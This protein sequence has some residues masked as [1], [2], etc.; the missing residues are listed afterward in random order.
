V[1]LSGASF[2]SVAEWSEKEALP[3]EV[4]DEKT[5]SSPQRKL[6][7]FFERSR[8]QWKTKAGAAKS[9]LKRLGARVRRLER[10]KADS[11][12]HVAALQAQVAEWQA[13]Y[14]QTVRELEELKKNIRTS[15]GNRNGECAGGRARPASPLSRPSRVAD[16]VLRRV[17][18]HEFA[19]C[20][21][22][23]GGVARMP[24]RRD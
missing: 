10:K 15:A 14:A 7:K 4:P 11:Q 2:Y 6:V 21:A 19:G 16:G 17:R 8:N 9:G 23:V 13:K 24:G 20:G 22:R 5:Y 18:S 12:Q 3:M 1:L